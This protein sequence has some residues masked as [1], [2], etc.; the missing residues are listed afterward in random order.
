M[1]ISVIIPTKD[2]LEYLKKA[3]P[4]FLMQEEVKEIIVVI[5]GSTD[6]TREFL[7]EYCRM[8]KRVRYLDNLVN[9]GIPFTKNRGIDSAKYEYIFLGEDDLELTKDFFKIL[10]R[11]MKESGADII[12]GRNIFR[13]DTET[14][15]QA[16][17]RTNKINGPYV[18]LKRI[19]IQTSMNIGDDS[20]EPIL[21]N[22]MLAK[23]SVFRDV[24]FDECY[25]VNF[26]REE[27]DFQLSARKKGYKIFCCPHA[28]CFNIMATNDRGGV[29]ATVGLRRA[30]W[31]IL[32]NRTFL[33][34]HKDFIKEN[35]ELGN[36]KIY[37][38]KFSIRIVYLET[39]FPLGSF[40][41]SRTK[42]YFSSKFL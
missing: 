33:R 16:I 17:D 31:V 30:K 2:R 1:E 4:T 9:R 18:N 40:V 34:K 28:I 19:E 27:T 21:A 37:I 15:K 39:V 11:H 32:N 24:K 10:S 23:T 8:N 3:L 20:E 6:G 25:K 22:P 29:H 35:F 38:I 13:K 7:E 5:D 14:N 36:F 42:R 26:W 41:T 12:C